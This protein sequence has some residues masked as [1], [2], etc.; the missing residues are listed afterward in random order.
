M[1]RIKFCGLRRADDVVVASRLADYIGFVFAPSKR[2][3]T[4]EQAAELRQLVPATVQVVGVFVSPTLQ[5]VEAAI[6]TVGLD[7]IQIHGMVD[8]AI[9]TQTKV[10][11]IQA[12]VAGATSI[13]TEADYILYD[14][15]QAGSGQ[16]FD[17]STD[18]ISTRPMFVAGGLTPSNVAAA[19]ARYQPFA[20]DVSSG[21]ETEFQKDQQKMLA[22]AHAVKGR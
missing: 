20:V 14:A 7:L 12:L 22:F 16:P 1:T 13:D 19:I 5:E 9:R 15:P 11:I 10:P 8:E 21:I 4:L 17:W 2:Q 18:L 3:V 6:E